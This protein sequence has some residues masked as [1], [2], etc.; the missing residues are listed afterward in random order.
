MKSNVFAVRI[1]TDGMGDDGLEVFRKM[2]PTIKNDGYVFA[3]END[4]ARQ[5]VQGWIR[6]ESEQQALRIRIKRAFPGIVG[7]K[8]YSIAKVRDFE[9]YS[10]YVLKGT[11]SCLPHIVA[12]HGLELGDAEVKEVHNRY[13][14]RQKLVGSS[15]GSIVQE[16]YIWA[17]SLEDVTREQVVV[18]TCE[19]ITKRD[20]PLMVHYVRGVVN[21]VMFKLGGSEK[22]YLIEYI[23][24]DCR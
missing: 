9:K 16:V 6:T 7:N 18:R 8:K 14:S 11:K 5:H 15:Q 23:N 22:K 24:A 4:A 17:N 10:E 21:S 20:K 1:H 2:L 3:L 12:S 19:E 13:W